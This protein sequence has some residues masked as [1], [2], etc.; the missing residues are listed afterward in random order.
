MLFKSFSKC[1][2]DQIQINDYHVDCLQ[3]VD[4]MVV[5]PIDPMETNIEKV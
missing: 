1:L 5:V 4:V 2:S 3:A